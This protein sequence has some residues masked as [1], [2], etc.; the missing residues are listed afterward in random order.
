MNKTFQLVKSE[1]VEIRI[2]AGLMGKIRTLAS[3]VHSWRD[4]K[5]F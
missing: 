1:T 4:Q 3:K 5:C 2:K